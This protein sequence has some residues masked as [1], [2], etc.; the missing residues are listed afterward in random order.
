[1]S[2]I[3]FVGGEKGGVGKSLTA[4]L[5][6]Q[7]F[8]DRSVPFAGIDADVSHGTL[9][10]YY[11]D[12]TRPVDL[13]DAASADEIANRALGSDR[14]VVVDLP[15]QSLRA[16]ERWMSGA[17]VVGLCRESGVGL[18]LWHVTD[19]GFDSVRDLETTLR[20]WGDAL[21]PI[22]VRNH[23]RGADFSQFDESDACRRLEERH[24][25]IDIQPLE[26]VTMSRVD[27]YGLSFWAAVHN[28]E[29]SALAP[30]QR[31]R[32]KRCLERSYE[33]LG[34]LEGVL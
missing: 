24:R 32:V 12:Y 17:D 30:L 20:R 22:A 14:A 13:E 4:R 26:S 3:H 21:D 34:K 19:G 5:L 29:G 6:S 7:W 18:T 23:G 9:V 27:R 2:H 31:Q 33:D 16:L 8:I 1:M 11:G 28:T 15:A 25:V 10:R